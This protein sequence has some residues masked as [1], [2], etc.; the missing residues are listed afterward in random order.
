M[1]DSSIQAWE[2]FYVIVGSSAGAL[3]GLQFVVL[4]LVADLEIQESSQDTVAAFGTPTVM[5]FCSALLIS[6]ILSAP[7][8][9]MVPLEFVLAAVGLAGV[10]YTLV[11]LMRARRQETY[12]PVLEDWIWHTILPGLAYATLLPASQWL[13]SNP[14]AL[15]PIGG[16][17]LLLVF[18]GIHNAY[19]SVIYIT[20]VLRRPGG[21]GGARS[22]AEPG[23]ATPAPAAPESVR[24]T[25][26]AV[27]RPPST[28]PP[29]TR[30]CR[31]RRVAP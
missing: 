16:A 1:I 3:T 4:T 21:R 26:P 29:R 6:A 27:P 2:S 18:V 23:A 8:T 7:W 11:V 24:A 13:R 25:P 17:A 15:F 12:A 19:D 14:A 5:H 30:R 10:I 22:A 20:L 28:A 31:R 9:S